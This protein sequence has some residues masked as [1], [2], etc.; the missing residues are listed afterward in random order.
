MN[1]WIKG[2]G[3]LLVTVFG[4]L[5]I[6]VGSAVPAWSQYGGVH[7]IP[8]CDLPIKIYYNG[9]GCPCDYNES[10]AAIQSAIATWNDASPDYDFFEYAGT[11]TND[12]IVCDYVTNLVNQLVWG[13]GVFRTCTYKTPGTDDVE[14][15]ITI[16]AGGPSYPVIC[17]GDPDYNEI[18]YETVLLH[19]LGHA[20]GMDHTTQERCP[21]SIM[22]PIGLPG[23]VQHE[24]AECDID[25]LL[26]MYDPE[27]IGD[28]TLDIT[29]FDIDMEYNTGTSSWDVTFIFDTNLSSKPT[30][31]YVTASNCATSCTNTSTEYGPEAINHAVTVTGLT[32]LTQYCFEV[33]AASNNTD[34]GCVPTVE[35]SF[36]PNSNPL[37][38]ISSNLHEIYC[39]IQVSW[40]TTEPA[41]GKKVLYKKTTESTWSQ[42]LAQTDQCDADLEHYAAFSVTPG[43]TYEYKVQSTVDGV[44]YESS[45][46]TKKVKTCGGMMVDPNDGEI[47]Q[48]SRVSLEVFPNPFNPSTTIT[49]KVP[50]RAHV[51]LTIYSATGKRIVD[52]AGGTYEAG[53]YSEVWEGTDVSGNSVA[54]G[55]Y[56]ARLVAGSE[57]VT[58][59]LILMK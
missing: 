3:L 54:S 17:D 24:L 42:V 16:D 8:L 11:T 4:L 15:D 34:T 53:S 29:N 46:Y 44:G 28:E 33:S 39:E 49:F 35:G 47:T 40:K 9:S 19:E 22:I 36:I 43:F 51:A 7:R 18:D 55:I 10:I 37:F 26:E 59:K 14:T 50:T 41:T 13:A 21:G 31:E 38:A 45:V 27:E 56:F 23:I 12:D 5:T 6:L 48:I 2:H 20:L 57:T 1:K 30:I 32:G 58:A 52:L 25:L